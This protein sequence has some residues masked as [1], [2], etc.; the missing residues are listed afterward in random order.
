MTTEQY[1]CTITYKEIPM[2]PFL[3]RY[4]FEMKD[5]QMIETTVRF[6]CELIK[7]HMVIGYREEGVTCAITLGKQYDKL[8]DAVGDHLLL[9]YCLECVGMELLSKAYEKVNQYVHE[10]RGCWIG[11]YRFPE[12]EKAQEQLQ[13]LHTSTVVWKKGMLR[14]AKSVILLA[15][16]VTEQS[17]SG[18]E[19]CVHCGNTDCVFRKKEE[20]ENSLPWNGNASAMG[21][22]MYS[23][24]IRRIFGNDRKLQE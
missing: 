21:T 23:Y 10:K 3:E 7:V 2:N 19:H 16:Y 13:S 9:S 5:R 17:Q 14:P 8:S 15:D 11:S 12:G 20:K 6:A 24:G 1:I 4:H 18:C 22:P